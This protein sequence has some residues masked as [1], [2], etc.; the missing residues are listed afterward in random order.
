[1]TVTL[2][3]HEEKKHSVRYDA[4]DEETAK[5]LRSIYIGKEALTKPYPLKVTVTIEAE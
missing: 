2:R 5:K 1:M 3:L 4:A